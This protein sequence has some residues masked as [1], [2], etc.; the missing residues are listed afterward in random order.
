MKKRMLGRTGLSVT[1]VCIGLGAVDAYSGFGPGLESALATIQR[2]LEGPFNF[3]DAS[4][5]CWQGAEGERAIARAVHEAGGLPDGFVLTSRIRP[6]FG[7]EFS[8]DSIVR[9][10]E[11]S[12]QRLR[13]DSL[14]LVLLQDP[15]GLVLR[16]AAA[17]GSP[18]ES[19]LALRDQ[20]L[21]RHLG[22]EGGPIDLQFKYL[23]TDAFDAVVSHI[24]YNLIDRAAEPL[25]QE[26]ASREVAFVNAA[27]FTG[28]LRAGRFT[29]GMNGE[30]TSR[31]ERSDKM[32]MI[33]AAYGIPLAA[34]GL[35]FSTLDP[36][37][38]STIVDAS[39]PSQAD[40]VT[41]LAQWR[42]PSGVWDDLLDLVEEADL[43]VR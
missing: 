12:L 43:A 14:P 13:L 35:Q 26:A 2:V 34:A 17:Q 7:L 15:E 37:V 11:E 23:A 5:E 40:F 6:A 8:G 36:R 31:L 42:I 1:S 19:L 9:A 32:R 39:T 28:S 21:I 20:G 24:P 33:C 29:H 30:R 41:D 22:I 4:N 38:A 27:P 25:I 10:V 16:A 18:L 3:I